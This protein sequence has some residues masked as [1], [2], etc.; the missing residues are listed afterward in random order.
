MQSYIALQAVWALYSS[1][2]TSGIIL[3]IGHELTST[4][5]IFDGWFIPYWTSKYNFAGK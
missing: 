5:P 2:R 3:D 1:G 4:V